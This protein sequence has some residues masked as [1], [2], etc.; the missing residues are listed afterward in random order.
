MSY[1][2]AIYLLQDAILSF[3]AAALAILL[4]ALVIINLCESRSVKRFVRSLRLYEDNDCPEWASVGKAMYL[5][6]LE[7]A[8]RWQR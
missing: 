6:E 7:R 2:E 1:S 4:I 3:C 8:E 5:D